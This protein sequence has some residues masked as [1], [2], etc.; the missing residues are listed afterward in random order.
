MSPV[1][2]RWLKI[3]RD[4]Q[5]RA[6]E[7][8][9]QEGLPPTANVRLMQLGSEAKQP[10]DAQLHA[11]ALAASI[12]GL[13]LASFCSSTQYLLLAVGHALAGLL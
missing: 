2:S 11:S 13:A 10:G 8:Q 9:Q 12:L 4:R 6:C 5:S 3:K 7:R 1:G